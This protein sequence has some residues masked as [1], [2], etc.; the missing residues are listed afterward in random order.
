MDD[1][2]E[3][4]IERQM[5]DSRYISKLVKGLLSNIV[6]DADEQATT[7]KHVIPVTGSITDT[8]KKDWGLN[9][10][11]NDI[12]APR[13]KRMN[14]L[15]Q[16]QDFGYFDKSIN[17]F[18]ISVPDELQKGFNKKRIDH[19][20]HAM[21]A[22]VIAC[23]TRDHVNYM[24]NQ[25][26]AK[27]KKEERYDLRDK[28]RIVEEKQITD[29]TTGNKRTIKVGKEFIKPWNGFPVDAKNALEKTVVSFKQNLRVINKTTNK[30]WQW[31]EKEGKL[32]KQLVKQTKGDSWA[33]RKSM[34]KDTVSGKVN[35]RIKKTLAFATGIKD[36]ENLVDK[37]L[38]SIL[39]KLISEGKDAKTITKYFKDNPY[40]KEGKTVK[41]VEVYAYTSKATATRMMLSESFSRKQLDC[42][43][44]SGIKNILENQLKNYI[45]EK[46]NERFDLAFNPDGVAAMNENIVELNGGKVHQPIYKVRVYEEG[47][48]F[49]VG[50]AGNK[51][52]K[53]VEAAK[54]TNLFFAI[55]WNEEKQKR[56][57]ETIPFNEVIEHQKQVAH[58][59]KEERTPVPINKEKGQ[60]L[61][62][63]SP[64]DL[65]YVP[66]AEEIQKTSLVNFKALSNEQVKK[67]YKVVSSS[68]YQCFF[69][70]ESVSTSIANK[71]EF[72][73]LNKMEKSIDDIMI[74][75]ICWKLEVDRLGNITKIIRGL[76]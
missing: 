65:V 47:S 71:I 44:D 17:A 39:K 31:V 9:D 15:T 70:H 57:Y 35:V 41:Q 26:A 73:A 63:L 34:H 10:K 69:I 32:K 4:F 50:Y 46:G 75:E 58:L 11:W 25:Y 5:N 20:H 21:D 49:N 60:F 29:K 33:I 27:D 18:R 59:P 72:S 61:F 6:K 38:K 24:N 64:N 37:R 28:L 22:L 55:Y 68:G 48:K 13:F 23:A 1:I 14:E 67:I 30:T 54:G 43:T 51:A 12:I 53:Y 66:T 62:S 56:E 2:P 74:K 16:S 42:V 19:R 36:W 7:S 3:K 45:D 52:R 8:L 40:Q 76:H